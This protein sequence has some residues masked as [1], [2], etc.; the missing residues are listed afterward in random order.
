[1]AP[2][3]KESADQNCIVAVKRTDGQVRDDERPGTSFLRTSYLGGKRLKRAKLLGYSDVG[4][5]QQNL[6]ILSFIKT[7][8]TIILNI[9]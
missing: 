2:R 7:L 6:Y 4:P 9:H 5:K 3:S 8:F 1:V